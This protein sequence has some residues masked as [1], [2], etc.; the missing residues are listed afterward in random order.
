LSAS[1]TSPGVGRRI[2]NKSRNRPNSTA[3]TV[4]EICCVKIALHSTTK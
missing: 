3:A 4:V 1:S 2:G